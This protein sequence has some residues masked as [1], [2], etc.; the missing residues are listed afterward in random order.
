MKSQPRNVVNVVK[1][2][3]DALQGIAC[4]FPLEHGTTLEECN[5]L[6]FEDNDI[7]RHVMVLRAIDSA[8]GVS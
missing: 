4:R 8:E 7:C 3:F 2:M 1:I 6:Q 5:C